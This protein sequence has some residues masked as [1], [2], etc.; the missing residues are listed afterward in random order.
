MF[1]RKKLNKYKVKMVDVQHT[2]DAVQNGRLAID[3]QLKYLQFYHHTYMFMSS[4]HLIMLMLKL[5]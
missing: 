3:S 5:L 2:F 4:C 1:H